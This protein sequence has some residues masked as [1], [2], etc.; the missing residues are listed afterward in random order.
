MRLG[1]RIAAARIEAGLSQ[2]QL[3]ERIGRATGTIAHY[4]A[5][6]V[7]PRP[8]ILAQIAE[9]TGK[10]VSYFYGERQTD[11][12]DILTRTQRQ[13]ED[14]RTRLDGQTIT[15]PPAE[16][17]RLPLLGCVP[18]GNWEEALAHAE[19]FM[20][21]PVEAIPADVDLKQAFL[22]RVHGDSMIAAGILD[23][24]VVLVEPTTELVDGTI[25]VVVANGDCTLKYLQGA[26]GHQPLLIPAN[27]TMP[28]MPVPEGA[29]IIGRVRALKRDFPLPPRRM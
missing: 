5:G 14:L 25:V 15:P 6:R 21:Y 23:G 16:M 17:I 12:T 27:P 1:Q 4:E 9:A 24:D 13:L 18:A 10:P 29:M 7:E 28:P 3:G 22:L 2:E 19:E 20:Q 11:L 26:G 8:R